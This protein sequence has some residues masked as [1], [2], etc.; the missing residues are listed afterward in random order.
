MT[1]E[2]CLAMSVPT[3]SLQENLTDINNKEKF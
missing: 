2:D 1:N 3:M